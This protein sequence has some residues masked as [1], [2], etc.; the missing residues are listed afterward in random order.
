[1]DVITYPWLV[2]SWNKIVK[3]KRKKQQQ[4]QQQQQTWSI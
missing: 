4:Q 3:Y 2:S 1:M